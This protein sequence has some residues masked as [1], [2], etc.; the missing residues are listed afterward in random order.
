MKKLNKPQEKA[1]NELKEEPLVFWDRRTTRCRGVLLDSALILVS[2]DLATV[3][4]GDWIKADDG[5]P[6]RQI[7][8]SRK[9]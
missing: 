6:D 1:M 2:K 9:A 7:T 8:I 5:R 3:I 4:E